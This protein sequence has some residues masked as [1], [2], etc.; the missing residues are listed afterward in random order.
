MK[1]VLQCKRHN[2]LLAFTPKKA[3]D[4]IMHIHPIRSDFPIPSARAS[5]VR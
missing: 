5:G 3:E 1:D 4:I 2:N